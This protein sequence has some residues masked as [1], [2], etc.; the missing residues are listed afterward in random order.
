[1]NQMNMNPN[2]MINFGFNNMNNNMNLQQEFNNNLNKIKLLNENIIDI[3]DCFEFYQKMHLFKGE[4][5]LF[6]GLCKQMSYFRIKTD[7]YNTPEVLMIVLDRE[8]DIQSKIKLKFDFQ[9]NL[10]NYIEDKNSGC[11]YE[12]ISVITKIGESGMSYHFIAICKN[13]KDN[14]WYQYNDE[15]VYPVTNF[16]QGVFDFEK[17]YILFYKKIKM[18]N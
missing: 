9:L 7:I 1:M 17:P 13:P 18:N 5:Q 16:N 15:F 6:C 11:L 8:L 12:L 2:M 10:F 3:Y 4:N 14:M